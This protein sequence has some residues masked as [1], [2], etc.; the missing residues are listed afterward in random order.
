VTSFSSTETFEAVVAVE[1]SGRTRTAAFEEVARLSGRSRSAVQSRFYDE[2][3]RRGGVPTVQTEAA[4]EPKRGL[5]L[6]FSR[7]LA[8]LNSKGCTPE[9]IAKTERALRRFAAYLA[10]FGIDP[11][12]VPHEVAQSYIDDLGLVKAVTTVSKTDVT[13]IKGAYQFAQDLG[14]TLVNPMKLVV[15]PGIPDMEPVTYSHQELRALLAEATHGREDLILHLFVY[16]GLR[17]NEV[18]KLK[19]ADIDFA[20]NRLSV[21]GKGHPP[22]LRH[23]PIHPALR[24]LLLRADATKREGQVFVVESNRRQAMGRDRLTQLLTRMAGRASVEW[25][26]TKPFRKTVSSV[27]Y[28]EGVRESYID[29]ILGHAPRTVNAR[30]YRRTE[31][32]RL[33]DAILKLYVSDPLDWPRLAKTAAVE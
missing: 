16:T 32:E 6:I 4:A 23:V 25:K 15:V 24:I 18:L 5:P 26:G 20:R 11:S 2:A 30:H 8:R 31:D 33:Q 14:E 12:K 27:L 3:K 19:F 13:A 1:R 7:Y 10:Q 17:R 29:A 21:L 22:K 28:E 9:H